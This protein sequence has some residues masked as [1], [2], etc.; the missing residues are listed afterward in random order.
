MCGTCVIHVWCV[1]GQVSAMEAHA[2]ELGYP[3]NFIYMFPANHG[4]NVSDAAKAEVCEWVCGS[5]GDP[6]REPSRPSGG[7]LGCVWVVRTGCTGAPPTCPLRG[8]PFVRP[9]V[10]RYY[11]LPPVSPLLPVPLVAPSLLRSFAPSPL[12]RLVPVGSGPGRS[13]CLGHPRL[14]AGRCGN[15]RV[16]VRSQHQ[17]LPGIV[18]VAVGAGCTASAQAVAALLVVSLLAVRDS[19]SQLTVTDMVPECPV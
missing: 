4:P 14:V 5:F 15:G 18:G 8:G 2:T 9:C 17:V 16:P 3:H 6:V 12:R 1:C 10:P 19:P 13:A 11:H 7:S